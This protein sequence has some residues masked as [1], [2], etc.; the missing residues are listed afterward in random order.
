MKKLS[1]EQVQFP[2]SAFQKEAP[3]VQL[4]RQLLKE[5]RLAL[6][7]LRLIWIHPVLTQR[8]LLCSLVRFRRLRALNQTLS[9]GQPMLL[10]QLEHRP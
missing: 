6:I 8:P 1:D 4:L 10:R 2:V 3:I 5:V 7:P 9:C